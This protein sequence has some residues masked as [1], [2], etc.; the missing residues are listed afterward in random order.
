MGHLSEKEIIILLFFTK[1][2]QAWAQINP[3]PVRDSSINK[4]QF[5]TGTGVVV[6]AV[7]A[8]VVVASGQTTAS[9]LSSPQ[10]NRLASAEKC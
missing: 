2:R 3:F 6:A 9:T 4:F 7:E 10:K 5:L 1:K 8:V